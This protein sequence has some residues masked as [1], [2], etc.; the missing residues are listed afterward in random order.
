MSSFLGLLFSFPGLFF[1]LGLVFVPRAGFPQDWQHPQHHQY[2][3]DQPTNQPTRGPALVKKQTALGRNNGSR[4][5]ALIKIPGPPN[6]RHILSF[7]WL[8]PML[9]P[10]KA[11]FDH[12][13][14]QRC[15]NKLNR[16]R[17]CSECKRSKRESVS[18]QQGASM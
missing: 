11:A 6:D 13:M 16:S 12:H 3:L 10:C 1:C 8:C 14:A 5:G 4:S 17:L 2:H 9:I 15:L 18:K 7:K